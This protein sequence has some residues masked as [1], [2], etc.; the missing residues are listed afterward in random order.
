MKDGRFEN[1]STN[2]LGFD[3]IYNFG[4]LL[5]NRVL[6]SIIHLNQ[7]KNIYG[8]SPLYFVALLRNLSKTKKRGFQITEG[9]YEAIIKIYKEVAVKKSIAKNIQKEKKEIEKLTQ[10]IY[11]IILKEKGMKIKELKEIEILF[12]IFGVCRISGFIWFDKDAYEVFSG[13]VNMVY[14]FKISARTLKKRTKE[15]LR[16]IENLKKFYKI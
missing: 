4:V 2:N 6:P 9:D 16:R 12:D 15:I 8:I 5:S 13:I 14:G 11:P 7:L 1:S 3:E 10:S